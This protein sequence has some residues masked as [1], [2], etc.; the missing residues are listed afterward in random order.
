M[1]VAVAASTLPAIASPVCPDEPRAACGNRVF[2][3]PP[4]TASFVQHDS[5]EYADGIKALAKEFPRF[6]KVTKFSDLLHPKAV[7]A[8]GRDLWLVEITDFDVSDRNKIPVAVSMSVHGPERAGL[9]GGVRY[10]E[11][12]V[13]WAANEP[14]HVLRNG[15]LEDSIEAPVSEVLSKVHLYLA[16]INPDGW[17]N[18]D[19][20]NG[21][22][23]ERG[24]ASGSDLNREW[25]TIGWTKTSY[26]TLSEPEAKAWAELMRSI[27][28]MLTSDIHGELTSAND[29]FADIM[30]PA[31]QWD[32]VR[33]ARE[34]SLARHMKSQVEWYFEQTNIDAGEATGQAGMTP[35][36]YATGFDVVGYDDAG[37]MGD[38]FTQ[39]FDAVDMDIEHFLSH[40][41]PNSTWVA[42]LE[43][44]HVAAVRG[45]IETLIVEALKFRDIE[46]DLELGHVG[47]ISSGN[48]AVSADGYG[49]PKPPKG[50]TPEPYSVCASR[51]LLDLSKA[52]R[53][54]IQQ[55]FP[56]ELRGKLRGLDT[57]VVVGKPFNR[58]SN[59]SQKR[60]AVQEISAFVRAGGNLVLTDK[61]V[62]L[63]VKLGVVPKSSIEKW[64]YTAG[65]VNIDDFND[66]YT[67]DVHSTASQTYYEVG[68][69]YSVD[70]DSSPHWVVGKGAWD[71]AK[72]VSV[73][74]VEDAN[75]VGL[76]RVKYGDGTI[77]FISA[78]LPPPTEKFD[79]FFGLADYAV[80][81]AGGQIFNN[82]IAFALR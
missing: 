58:R 19:L 82:M 21:G 15:T 74:H 28:P 63:L 52:T 6:M 67:K 64:V 80:T 41:A 47:F 42:P 9:E 24:N 48:C 40:S 3:E 34:E 55:V 27:Q 54:A 29:S 69:G 79:H 25:P 70:E 68:L 45:E 61:G 2:P 37:F 33:Q 5:G 59:K 22:V 62:K 57:L 77:G 50:V 30:I 56:N 76:G 60:A 81:V 46:V 36:E 66:P 75:D 43:E 44:A 51:Y 23:F 13:R 39:E 35:A 38:W 17:S 1:L 8:G 12:L 53:Y 49:G 71:K 73:A 72:G 11:D 20:A 31:G 26:T 4:N 7:S 16:D 78:L 18:G 32:P 14:D 10:M 65:H